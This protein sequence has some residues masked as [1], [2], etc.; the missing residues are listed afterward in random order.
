MASAIDATK[1]LDGVPASKA[2]LRANLAAAKAEIEALQA[3]AAAVPTSISGVRNRLLNPSMR[4]DRRA[5]GS[6]SV[7]GGNKS[8]Y[9]DRWQFGSEVPAGASIQCTTTSG[10]GVFRSAM[11]ATITGAKTPAATDR[12]WIAQTIEAATMW[13]LQYGSTGALPLV[14]SFWVRGSTAGTYS[15]ALQAPGFL[16]SRIGTFTINL[17][18][19][20]EYKTIQFG[21]DTTGTWSAASTA[22]WTVR[23]DLGSGSSY[24][25]ASTGVWLGVDARATPSSIQLCATL[26]NYIEITD[27][28]LEQGLTPTALERRPDTLEQMLTARYYETGQFN[29]ATYGVAGGT[30]FQF[31]PFQTNKRGTPTITR[32]GE[33]TNNLNTLTQTAALPGFLPSALIT[34]TG[35]A[36]WS[37][38]YAADAELAL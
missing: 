20:W 14:L 37:A 13:D 5:L 21:G 10:P 34:A 22:F 9:L 1:P 18:G 27:V 17:P 4:I 8:F 23:F 2:D 38:S 29:I 32:S 26:S 30:I 31:V 24:Q 36:A 11:R 19:T 7:T 28:Q 3:L 6:P 25:S 35:S 12:H 15:V 16:R 33:T